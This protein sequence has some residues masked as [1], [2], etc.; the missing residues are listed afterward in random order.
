MSFDGLKE[1][2]L[3]F[4]Q[5]GLDLLRKLDDRLFATR[6]RLPMGSVGG[7]MRHCIDFYARFLDGLSDGEI[8]YD[9]RSR[10]PR[11]EV[12]RTYAADTIAQLMERL[13]FLAEG[14]RHDVGLRQE[15]SEQS[16]RV[17]GHT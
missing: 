6:P 15:A 10:D 9:A 14:D 8:D 2:N 12:D 17:D 3:L 7:H 1:D 4:L 5:Q 11:L 13:S 16:S